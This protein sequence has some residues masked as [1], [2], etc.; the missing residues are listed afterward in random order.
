MAPDGTGR[1]R[2]VKDGGWPAFSADGR[3]LFFH[4]ERQGRWGVWRI[5]LDGSGLE[6]IT[7]PMST[8]SPSASGD[9]TRLTVAAS[10]SDHRQIGLVHL[11]RR[12]LTVLTDEPAAPPG[13]PGAA[14]F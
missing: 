3:S 9:G 1:R 12:E 13:N 7:P 8:P 4:G 5:G 11:S 6:R 14:P 2:V 10:R